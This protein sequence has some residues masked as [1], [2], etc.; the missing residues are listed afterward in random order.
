[1]EQVT[2]IQ[3]AIN[4]IEK[5]PGIRTAELAE[6]IGVPVAKVAPLIFAATSSRFI[7]SCKVDRPGLAATNEYR[8]SAGVVASDWDEYRSIHAAEHVRAKRADAYRRGAD[9]TAVK[10]G[11]ADVGGGP[12][13]AEA[14]IDDLENKIEGMS[15]QIACLQIE[16]EVA[17]QTIHKMELEAAQAMQVDGAGEAAGKATGYLVRANKRVPRVFA[18]RDSAV[19]AALALA[20]TRGRADVL[21][22]VPVGKARRKI[23]AS[24]DWSGS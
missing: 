13:V 1:M 16:L 18:K 4:V 19:K 10:R 2:K 15:E 20:R 11:V 7:V 21:A 22:L 14:A 6:A 23:A 24:V 12:A 5:G 17:Q 8:L 9:S 3:K